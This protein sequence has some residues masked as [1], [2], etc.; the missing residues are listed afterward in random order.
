MFY[1][2]SLYSALAIFA[3][4]LI[5][6]IGTWFSLTTTADSKAIPRAK[7]LSAALRG[8]P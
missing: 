3:L 6:K 2:I 5:Y 8:S 1:S 7:R 4:G